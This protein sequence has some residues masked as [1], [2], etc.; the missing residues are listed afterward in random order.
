LVLAVLL[1]RRGHL[2]TVDE[3]IDAVWGAQPPA[4]AVSVLRTYVS[5]LR[6]VLEPCRGLGESPKLIV[7]AANGYLAQVPDEALDLG[8]FE[9]QVAR[10]KK[11]HAMGEVSAAADLLH[12]ALE[13]WHETPL[14]GLP[15]PLAHAERT[16]LEEKRLSVL[17]AR[18]DS[19]VQLGR[20]NEVIAE[21]RALV[22]E[23]P[24]RERLCQLLMLA[25]YR[26][27]RQAEALACYRMFDPL[28]Y[29][30]TFPRSPAGSANSARLVPCCP[31]T[32]SPCPRC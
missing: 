3:F 22:E 14:A 29:R 10:A 32:A 31:H 28:N 9:Q 21:L 6:K 2:V 13:E 4:A 15:G 11:L 19:D 8:M 23:N 18:L 5:R 16:R 27:G 17:E 12:A 26:S 24:L 25:L 7:S 30:R 1:L 20:H